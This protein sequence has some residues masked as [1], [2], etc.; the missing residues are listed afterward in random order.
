[1]AFYGDKN[2]NVCP[3]YIFSSNFKDQQYVLVFLYL[4]VHLLS[5]AEV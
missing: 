3:A 2:K 4:H 1:M 5:A